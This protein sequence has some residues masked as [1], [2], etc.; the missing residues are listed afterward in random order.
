MRFMQTE[1]VLQTA[2]NV[3][4]WKGSVDPFIRLLILGLF[5]VMR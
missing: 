1:S 2:R 3:N 5:L 4:W